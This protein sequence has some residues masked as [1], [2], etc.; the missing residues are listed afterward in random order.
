MS[1]P[2]AA[3][4]EKTGLL[5]LA[6]LPPGLKVKA[7]GASSGEEGV[8]HQRVVAVRGGVTSLRR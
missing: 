3:R 5:S 6:T 1:S 7:L 2:C 8:Q 4:H